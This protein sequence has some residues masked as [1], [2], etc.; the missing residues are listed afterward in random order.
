DDTLSAVDAHVGRWIFNN[1]LGPEGILKN[2][3][4]ILV[5]HAINYLKQCDHILFLEFGKIVESGTYA[6]LISQEG[7][8]C[9]LVREYDTTELEDD[10]DDTAIV[11]SKPSAVGAPLFAHSEQVITRNGDSQSS[12]K[13]KPLPDGNKLTTQEERA[14]GSVSWRVYA[15]YALACGV[16]TTALYLLMI[17]VAQAT[18]VAQNLWLADWSRE[19]DVQAQDANGHVTLL[20]RL[21]VYGILGIVFALLTVSQTLV[22]FSRDQSVIDEV[23]PRSFMSFFST[24]AL[25]AASLIVN[26]ATNPAFIAFIAPLSVVYFWVSRY[27]LYTSRE[28]KRLEAT[29]RSPIY[30]HFQETLGGVH[31]IRAYRDEARFIT[32]NTYRIDTNQKANY[33]ANASNRWLAMRLELVGSFIILG[34]T[35]FSVISIVTVGGLAASIVGLAVSY[36]LNITQSLNWMVRQSC[37]IETNIV[38]VERLREYS[39]LPLEAPY[40]IPDRRPPTDWPSKGA[41]ELSQFS[42]RYRPGLDLVLS[43]INIR[44]APTQKIGLVGRTGSGKSSL[45]LSLFRIIEPA[46]G[47]ILIDGINI[48]EIGLFDLRSKLTVIPQDPVLFQGTVRRN[49]DPMAEATD[50]KIWN[51]L[52]CARLA[53]TIGRLVGGLE[54]PVLAGGSNF[55]VGQRQLIC[56]ARALLRHTKLLV[57]DE[58]TASVDVETD[59][60]IQETIR[61]EFKD[62]TIITIA[63]RINTILDYDRIVVLSQGKV[64]EA[65]RPDRLLANTTSAFHALAKEAGLIRTGTPKIGNP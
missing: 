13:P 43:D 8:V 41:L 18:S 20:W 7:V 57:L 36:A 38:S 10:L 65:D 59:Q 58:A 37:E 9:K 15:T 19:N 23:L 61:T 14:E 47:K 12:S 56:L 3:T 60:V 24:L 54:A 29:S 28:L 6:D 32:D 5:T 1:V 35:L 17:V 48:S 42:T 50:A 27:Y 46:F 63:H 11:G 21:G 22:A 49:L 30:A 40:E 33:P 53:D 44:I 34:S 45:A 25:V 4:R 55:S 16:W 31:T 64:V 2:R 62:C 39:E 52:R 51:A 26:S